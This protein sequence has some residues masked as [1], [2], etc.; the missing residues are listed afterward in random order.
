[1]QPEMLYTY[2]TEAVE[3]LRERG[4][5]EVNA[6]LILGSGLGP[7]TEAFEEIAT[8]KYDDI[9][10]MGDPGA[11]GHK[12]RVVYASYGRS[13]L[14]IFQ[15]RMHYY[16]GF[17]MW[18]VAFPVRLV[19]RLG[20]N[21][22]ITTGAAGGINPEYNAGDI[23]VISDQIN[24]LPESPLRGRQDPRLGVRFPDMSEPFDLELRKLLLRA[25]EGLP[26]GVHEGVYASLAGPS[27]ETKAEYTMLYRIGADCVAMSIIPE[28]IVA[29]QEELKVAGMAVISNVC[30]PPER[31]VYTTSEDV[32]ETVNGSVDHIA[33]LVRRLVEV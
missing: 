12:G 16:E 15:G 5:G 2:I 14:L 1:M 3:Y 31:V 11:P 8:I 30:Y 21:M 19:S 25:G 6:G 33:G 20:A 32:I 9:P 29:V 10:H 24:L 4:V 26:V 23:V 17:P 13:K 22:L 27:L 18:Q 28:V 7:V